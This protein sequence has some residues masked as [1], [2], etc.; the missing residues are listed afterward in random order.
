MSKLKTS[1][2]HLPSENGETWSGVFARNDADFRAWVSKDHFELALV[3][4][5]ANQFEWESLIKEARQ[6]GI[7]VL[8]FGSHIQPEALLKARQAG[9]YK[10]VANSAIVQRFAELIAAR[11]NPATNIATEGFEVEE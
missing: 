10:A 3:D 2:Q 1:L 9:A 6:A 4:T 5:Q 11:H 7:P 8:A